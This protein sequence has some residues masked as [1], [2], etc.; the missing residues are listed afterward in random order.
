MTTLRGTVVSGF[1][2][3]TR[4]MTEFPEA[5]RKAAGED[6]YPGTINIDVG[7]PIAIREHRRIIGSEIG[8]PFQDLLLEPC[9]INGISAWRIRPLVL[10]ARAGLP[11]G[12]GGHGDHILEIS[13]AVKIPDASPGSQIE[14]TFFRDDIV[15]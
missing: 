1:R 3:F 5:F 4:R 6:L 12:E 7:K 8:E 10:D 13:C 15:H 2:H 14:I 9:A 11:V